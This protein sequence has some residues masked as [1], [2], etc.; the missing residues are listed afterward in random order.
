MKIRVV[1]KEPLKAPEVK[2]IEHGLS[3]MQA[4]V[5]GGLLTSVVDDGLE[6]KGITFYA[7]DEG[8]LLGFEPNILDSYRQPIVGPILL[9]GH[10]NEGETVTLTDEQVATALKFFEDAPKCRSGRL[11]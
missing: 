8:L 2:E 4:C 7:N 5:G 6:S 10:N 11:G 9:A 1:T 3:E